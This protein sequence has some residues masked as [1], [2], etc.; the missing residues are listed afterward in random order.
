MSEKEKRTNDGTIRN[1]QL[2]AVADHLT[3]A[4]IKAIRAKLA[5]QGARTPY[6]G[7]IGEKFYDAGKGTLPPHVVMQ[8]KDGIVMI[9]L[10]ERGDGA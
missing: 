2:D 3:I 5:D 1:G 9:E 4:D 8:R 10:L 6:R 7:C